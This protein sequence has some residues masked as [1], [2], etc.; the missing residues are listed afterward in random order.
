VG[1]HTLNVLGSGSRAAST[2]LIACCLDFLFDPE[3][4]ETTFLRNDGKI[5][6]G[7]M[8][9]IQKYST[10]IVTADSYSN[11]THFCFALELNTFYEVGIA[12]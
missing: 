3:N 12:Q 1:K 10:L 6:L 2:V 7:Y 9:P 11:L 4:E 5:M 8:A